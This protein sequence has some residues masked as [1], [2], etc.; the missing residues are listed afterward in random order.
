[1]GGGACFSSA[2][3]AGPCPPMAPVAGSSTP[4]W[5]VVE[6]PESISPDFSVTGSTG[7]PSAVKLVPPGSRSRGRL[8]VN[9]RPCAPRRPASPTWLAAMP[10]PASTAPETASPLLLLVSNF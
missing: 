5:Y 6:V 10:V 1:M 2:P 8:G 4:G 3:I 7:D 9:P